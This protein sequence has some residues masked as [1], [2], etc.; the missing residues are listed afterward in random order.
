M[1]GLVEEPV[2][3]LS[4]ARKGSSSRGSAKKGAR[5]RSGSAGRSRKGRGS[6]PGSP[7]AAGAAAADGE[8]QEEDE[9][10][11]LQAAADTEGG[12][13][14]IADYDDVDEGVYQLRM[15][16]YQEQLEAQRQK[17]Q[18][19][20]AASTSAGEAAAEGLADGA[21]DD[22]VFDGG[23]RVPGGLWGQLFDYQ[24]TGVKWLWELHTQRAGGI[25]GDEMGLGKTIQVGAL[26]E[27][28]LVCLVCSAQVPACL[29][30][31]QDSW[32]SVSSCR[33]C[34]FACVYQQY[35]ASS[36]LLALAFQ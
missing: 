10:L 28:L 12:R 24:R 22:V 3:N 34:S 21:A 33:L 19:D 1:A 30:D 13:D 26:S 16:R 7:T 32:T 31:L 5:Q 17:Q 11:Q 2:G 36:L 8:E 18:Q 29:Q 25:I 20:A 6:T 14:E 15:E 35:T 9:L 23:F 4:A 27:A